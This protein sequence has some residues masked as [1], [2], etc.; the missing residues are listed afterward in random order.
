M[1]L[2]FPIFSQNLRVLKIRF[3]FLC[4]VES[5]LNQMDPQDLAHNIVLKIKHTNLAHHFKK[6]FNERELFRDYIA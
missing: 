3:G 1:E 5:W 4:S 6:D 2:K